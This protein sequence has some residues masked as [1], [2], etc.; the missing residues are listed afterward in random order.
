VFIGA[1]MLLHSVFV[2]PNL[3]SLGIIVGAVTI[4]V[5]ASLLSDR[6]VEKAAAKSSR[7]PNSDLT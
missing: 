4:G 3:V 5:L 6:A 1:K 2:L 7:A